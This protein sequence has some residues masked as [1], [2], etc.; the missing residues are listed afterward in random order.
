MRR[1]LL[2]ALLALCP[3]L[4]PAQAEFRLAFRAEYSTPAALGGKSSFWASFKRVVMAD[5]SARTAFGQPMS[6]AVDEGVT[7]V[8]DMKE[9][10]VWKVPRGSKAEKL[11][12]PGGFSSPVDLSLSGAALFVSDSGAGVVWRW[13]RNTGAWTR[14]PEEFRRPTGLAWVQERGLLLVADTE[15]H[16]VLAWDGTALDTLVSEGLNFPTDVAAYG[17]GAFLV[18]DSMDHEIEVRAWTGEVSRRF[19]IAGD[20]PGT[21]AF[22]RGVACDGE[23]RVYVSDVHQAW[24]QAFD[25]E[26][27]LLGVFGGKGT[28]SHP[29][30]L[31]WTKGALWV[32]DAFAGRVLELTAQ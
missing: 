22:L 18:A 9:R 11:T 4:L 19:G 24:I 21:F 25:R 1:A 10:C 32:A 31:T 27:K 14:L 13:D 8:A 29:S 17:K 23:G 28:L 7:F 6:V 12:P 15:A 16:A 26:G 5:A 20:T 3:A 2:A 30:Y